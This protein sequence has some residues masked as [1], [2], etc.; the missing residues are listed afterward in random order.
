MTTFKQEDLQAVHQHLLAD[1][2]GENKLMDDSWHQSI[3][4]AGYQWWQKKRRRWIV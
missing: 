2:L 1:M 3:M 4:E